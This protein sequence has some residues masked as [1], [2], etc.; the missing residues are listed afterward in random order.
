MYYLCNMKIKIFCRLAT[1]EECCIEMCKMVKESR[2]I[3]FLFESYSKIF[4]PCKP[5]YTLGSKL[6]LPV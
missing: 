3:D 5:N 1:Y 4:L 2:E 6:N